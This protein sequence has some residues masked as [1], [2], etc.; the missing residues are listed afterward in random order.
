[1][2]DTEFDRVRLEYDTRIQDDL[3]WLGLSW[4][5][6]IRRQSELI[7]FYEASIEPLMKNGL[8]Y[9]CSCSR[10]DIRAA[11]AAPQEGTPHAVY[12]G[13]CRARPL[14]DRRPGDALR[15]DLK[16]AFDVTGSDALTFKET[17]HAYEGQHRIEERTAL[18]KIGDIVLVRKSDGVVAYFLASALDDADQGISHVVRG[19]DLFAFTPIQVIL[20]ALL[21]L[22]TPV[23][24]HH[25]LIRD[26]AGKR[27]AKRDDARSIA[28]YRDDGLSPADIRALIG[29]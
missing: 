28:A 3:T 11:V 9:P 22:P 15:L 21:G 18:D 16:K 4:D 19:Q 7:Q 12:P 8:L 24:H 1:M 26:E 14:S 23:Y 5:G 6:P 20:Q 2:E 27:L 25:R 17:G 10:S 29:L 13:T